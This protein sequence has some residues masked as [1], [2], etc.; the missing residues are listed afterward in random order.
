MGNRRAVGDDRP[1]RA[2]PYVKDLGADVELELARPVHLE[3][4][5]PALWRVRQLALYPDTPDNPGHR[6]GD[7]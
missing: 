5:E 1:L 3:R 6:E 7:G 4:A 2:C